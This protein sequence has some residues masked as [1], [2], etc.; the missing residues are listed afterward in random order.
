VPAV[1]VVAAAGDTGATK[2]LVLSQVVLSL[3]LPFA[4]VPL[5]AFTASRAKMGALVSPVWLR[6]AAWTIAAVVIGLNM[7]LLA[8]FVV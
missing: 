6:V 5:V 1:F 7:T 2:L 3:Q 8:G 4:V